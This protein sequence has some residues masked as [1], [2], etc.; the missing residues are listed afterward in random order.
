[1]IHRHVTDGLRNCAL[2]Y[3]LGLLSV[4]EATAVAEHLGEGCRV[5][6]REI[7]ANRRLI[8]LLLSQRAWD[9]PPSDLRQ[10]LLALIET[11]LCDRREPG[12]GRD[13]RGGAI[14]AG[15]TIVRKGLE[16][17]MVGE[18]QASTIKPLSHH[19]A[20]GIR[21]MLVRLEAAG[22]YPGFRTARPVELYIV[23]GDLLVNHERLGR[24]DYCA[25]PAGTAF[26]DMES[27]DGCE[28]LLLKPDRQRVAEEEER[29]ASF[30]L[31][32][33]RAAEGSWLPTPA[34]GVTVK[35][36]FTD[37]LR[38]TETYLVRAEPG[39]RMPRHRHVTA[40]RTF[41]LEGDGRMGTVSL[42]AGDFYRAEAGTMHEVS[43]TE[44][45]CLCITLA[46]ITDVAD[47]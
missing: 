19:D 14:P 46:S 7:R 43:W 30:D 23:D 16:G 38:R 2:D 29:A 8:D 42:E 36:L 3:V 10:R 47:E 13:V 12:Q 24:G 20:D 15:W 6:A 44:R 11:D 40:D 45:G 21:I 31:I 4:A 33:V 27:R 9:D 35:P 18:G 25:A 26:K 5:C 17:W 22:L 32:V 1:M 28:F 34:R 39:S 37:P 41:F